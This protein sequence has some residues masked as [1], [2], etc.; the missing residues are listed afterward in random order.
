MEPAVAAG[1]KDEDSL[2]VPSNLHILTSLQ[3]WTERKKPLISQQLC[4][5]VHPTKK[6]KQC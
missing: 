4:Q 6:T 3:V 2:C 5:H 1:E